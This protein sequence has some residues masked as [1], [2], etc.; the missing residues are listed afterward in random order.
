MHHMLN[1]QDCTCSCTTH[2]VIITE[3]WIPNFEKKSIW[4]TISNESN[5]VMTVKKIMSMYMY[6]SIVHCT[7]IIIKIERESSKM[8]SI[9]LISSC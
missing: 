8:Q 5:L 2:P 3:I 7:F 9:V 6:F 4:A 1:K